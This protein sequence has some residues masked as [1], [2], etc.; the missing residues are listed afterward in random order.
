MSD[1]LKEDGLALFAKGD[2]QA[3]LATFQAAA[4]AYGAAGDQFGQAEM[5]NNL[6]VL[7]RMRRDWRA[8]TKALT[9]AR[10]IFADIE[11]FY[12][13]AQVWANLGD[14]HA[15]QKQLDK[16]ASAYGQASSL[17][18]KLPNPDE[19]LRW[20]W[21]QALRAM[22]L[23]RMRQRRIMEAMGIMEQSLNARGNLDPFAWLFRALL[24]F[25]LWLM[26]SR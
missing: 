20:K 19:D 24:R 9:E 16:A 18:A 22:S 10:T 25:A 15:N 26:G 13:E 6:G 5:L 1:Q 2:Y 3:A 4:D 7:H 11:D 8:A 23:I 21:G 14:L 12:F 17:F